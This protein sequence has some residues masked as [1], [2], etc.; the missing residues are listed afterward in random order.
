MYHVLIAK[1]KDCEKSDD[2]VSL[3]YNYVIFLFIFIEEVLS[4]GR[5]NSLASLVLKL[6]F[7]T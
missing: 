2:N 1:E 4:H 3:L 7:P 5:K 6:N